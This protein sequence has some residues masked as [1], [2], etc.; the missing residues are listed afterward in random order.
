MSPTR[1]AGWQSDAV[2]IMRMIG[3]VSG[4]GNARAFSDYLYVQ[5]IENKV[6]AEKDGSG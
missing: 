4:E 3:H 2:E 1:E 5:G 6:E